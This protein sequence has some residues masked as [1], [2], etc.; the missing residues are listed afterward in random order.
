VIKHPI[1]AD[2]PRGVDLYAHP[3]IVD[4]VYAGTWRREEKA[5]S[6][7]I[8]TSLMTRLTRVHAKGLSGQA[9]SMSAFLKLPVC[10]A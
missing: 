6:V 4:G 5:G 8:S 10:L 2:L 7:R 1:S 3:L 9:A